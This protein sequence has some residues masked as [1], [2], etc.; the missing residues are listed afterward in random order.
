MYNFFFTMNIV[1]MLY[2]YDLIKHA[3]FK[4]RGSVANLKRHP[5]IC[6]IENLVISLKLHN[7]FFVMCS[8]MFNIL[9]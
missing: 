6:S 2:F 7:T 5:A 8:L 1:F 4:E 3:L 9:H